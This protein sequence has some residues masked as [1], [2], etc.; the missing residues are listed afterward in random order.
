[1]TAAEKTRILAERVM[2]WELKDSILS[3]GGWVSRDAQR[4]SNSFAP[5]T[6]LSHAGEV[7][8]AMRAKGWTY[9]MGGMSNGS[10]MVVFYR[11]TF[12]S[13]SAIDQLLPTAI[14]HAALL[15]HEVKEEEL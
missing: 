8:E 3:V 2:G 1:M 15:A 5:L 11:D 12:T 14:C 7:L 9:S 10:H 6:N 13:E 4:G